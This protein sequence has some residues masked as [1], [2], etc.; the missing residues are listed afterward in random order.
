MIGYSRNFGSGI[1][2]F[3]LAIVV[4]H[5]TRSLVYGIEQRDYSSSKLGFKNFMSRALV[6]GDSNSVC[7]NICENSEAMAS[8]KSSLASE[9]KLDNEK[10]DTNSSGSFTGRIFHRFTSI[11]TRSDS[12]FGR[13]MNG[14][15]QLLN[16]KPTTESHLLDTGKIVAAFTNSSV[17][18]KS[19]ATTLRDEGKVHTGGFSNLY[20]LSAENMESVSTLLDSIVGGIQR[21]EALDSH[22]INC[23]FMQLLELIRDNTIP[24]I[25]YIVQILYT[26]SGDEEIL[27][28]FNTYLTNKLNQSASVTASNDNGDKCMGPSTT[29]SSSSSLRLFSADNGIHHRSM[30]G[31]LATIVGYV[32]LGVLWFLLSLITIIPYLILDLVFDACKGCAVSFEPGPP[33]PSDCLCLFLEIFSYPSILIFGFVFNTL[34]NLVNNITG[35]NAFNRLLSLINATK[36]SP[37]STQDNNDLM[38]YLHDVLKS[39]IDAILALP[40]NSDEMINLSK[41]NMVLMDEVVCE[42]AVL[43]CSNEA[44][45]SASPFQ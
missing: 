2:T 37:G 9:A 45:L 27:D 43:K 42:V 26:Q 5:S 29:S 40:H 4:I 11:F 19:F 14:L 15:L 32:L 24:N 33:G 41:T 16:R 23:Y 21:D 22:T 25:E 18:I 38:P 36:S 8:F 12:I 20:D 35:S 1:V 34:K 3:V 30:Q 17:Q 13:L 7:T 44:L 10:G 31:G 39:P 28:T 6:E